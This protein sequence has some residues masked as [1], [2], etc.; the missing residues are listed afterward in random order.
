M[1]QSGRL[2]SGES[3]PD[4][5]WIGSWVL[6]SKYKP[7]APAPNRM[8]AAQPEARRHNDWTIKN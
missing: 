4:T 1:E 6:W 2:I 8:M 7:F 3:A 5:H